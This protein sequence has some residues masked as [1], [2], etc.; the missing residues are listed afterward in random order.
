MRIAH[1]TQDG[2]IYEA[3]DFNQ[4]TDFINMKRFL[5]CPECHGPAFYRGLTRN[6]RE[7]CFGARPHIPGCTLAT[8]EH[9]GETTGQGNEE[10]ELLTT[11]QR[12]VLDFNFGTAEAGEGAQPAGVPIATGNAGTQ[13]DNGP[14][15]RGT[16]TRRLGPLLRSLIESDE[17]RRSPQVI[18]VPVIGEFTVADFFVNF[19]DVTNDHI[20]SYH[21]F[22]GMVPD[23][24]KDT[25]G[26]LWL[27]SGG[28]ENMSARLGLGDIEAT[29][30][31]FNI[32]DEEDIAG[33]YVLVLGDLR[34]GPS[35][36]RYVKIT[37]ASRFTLR[38]AR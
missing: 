24:R 36:K 8:L 31:R 33:A 16:M 32:Q 1:C 7:A 30:R 21:G 15:V 2:V 4:T 6:G 38:L 37:E 23:A 13:G 22:W 28:R 35:R 19:V 14:A 10:D 9:D 5:E 20:G 18:E 26:N 3:V 27:N 29:Y 17:F 34:V 12:I 25:Q 11:G